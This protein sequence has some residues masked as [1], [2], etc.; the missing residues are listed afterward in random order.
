M[1]HPGGIWPVSPVDRGHGAI[2]AGF[3]PERK[4]AF[5][6]TK[7]SVVRVKAFHN[8]AEKFHS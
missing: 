1:S 4:R 7:L 6:S 2:D 5:I 8:R 3:E